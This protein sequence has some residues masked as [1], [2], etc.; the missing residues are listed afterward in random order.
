MEGLMK[1]LTI[2]HAKWSGGAQIS[3]VE[4]LEL[5]R[6]KI[7]LKAL[8]CEDAD[9]RF[10][11]AINSIGIETYKAPCSIIMNCPVIN[12]GGMK[13][14]IEWADV[15]WIT[16]VEYL[17]APKIK[18]I[19]KDIPIIAHLRSYALICPWWGALY[20]FKETCIEGCSLYRIIRCKQGINLELSRI[21]LLSEARAGLYWLL[22]LTKGPLDYSRW[23]HVMKDAIE[24]IDGYIAI[25]NTLWNIHV[26]HIQDLSG[27][28]HEVVYN[29]VTAPSKHVNISE[30][31][32]FG[33]YIIYS[34]G[35][36]PIKGP[37][38]LLDAWRDISKEFPR[39]RL[40]MIGCK[41][42]WIEKLAKKR[43]LKNVIFTEKLSPTDCYHIMY[44]AR[45]VV[46]PSIWP[47]P[48]GRIPVEANRLGV[49]AIVSSTGGLPET[50]VGGITGYTFRAGDVND[51]A[52]K[53]MWVLEG[54]FD[55]EEVIRYSYEKINP[56]REVE[57]LIKFFES[58][59]SYGGRV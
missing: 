22:D 34:S 8:V 56:H 26:S 44:R 39:L 14:L 2:A 29:P 45:A 47:E 28:S 42:S 25:S 49:P 48:F 50:I 33:E 13:K 6:Y 11:S 18:K 46:M 17:A 21:G 37:H 30:E 32:S 24:N 58:M 1:V 3:I 36:N 59:I 41:H 23:R 20:G 7:E 55:R 40:Y 35:P 27:T 51:L 4:F 43:G 5:L 52:K 12:V 57:K 19:R 15:I 54:D 38:I 31:E 9:K 16:D 10:I 53:I